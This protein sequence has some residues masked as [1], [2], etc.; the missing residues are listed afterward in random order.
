[1]SLYVA[2]LAL[3]SGLGAALLLTPKKLPESDRDLDE[4]KANELYKNLAR[5]CGTTGIFDT[6]A[7][8]ALSVALAVGALGSGILE[9][10]LVASIVAI[11][12]VVADLWC[13][14]AV[15]LAKFLFY[16]DPPLEEVRAG[17]VQRRG[18]T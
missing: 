3:G 4:V 5:P 2:I 12:P 18:I 9:S 15:A 7:P 17:R 14:G 6:W 8:F 10:F 13:W 1:M 11:L 16:R